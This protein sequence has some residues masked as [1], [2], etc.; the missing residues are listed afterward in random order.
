MSDRAD[1]RTRS[2]R[3]RVAQV[4]A[5]LVVL[6]LLFHD[7]DQQA[8]L[9]IWP[10]LD[11]R[12]LA[13]ALALKGCTLLLHELRLWVSLN[14]PRPPVRLVVGIGLASGVLNLVLPG[15]AG[16]LAAIGMLV[17][18]CRVRPGAAT[19]AVGVVAFLEAA[20]FGLTLVVVLLLGADRWRAVVGPEQWLQAV[21]GVSAVTLF[22]VFVALGVVLLT[23]RFRGGPPE[24]ASGPSPVQLVRDAVLQASDNLAAPAILALNTVLALLQVGGIVGAFAMLFPAL[25]L[26]VALPALAASGVLAISALA[27]VLLPPSYGAGP[28]AAAVLVLGAFGLTADDAFAYSVG[29]WLVSQVPA[30]TLG[31]PAFYGRGELASGS[32]GSPSS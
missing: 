27:S 3:W 10:R 20:M 2:R 1:A 14:P 11:L 6:A 4:V 24:E 9:S 23:R 22:G 21:S 30:V 17:R 8:I 32:E 18:E 26:D 5:S 16:D 25:G 28:A 13:A 7:I 15:R 31:L 19:A 29:W 12:W